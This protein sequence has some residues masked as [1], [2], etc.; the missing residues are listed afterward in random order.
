MSRVTYAVVLVWLLCG[1][2]LAESL[3]DAP[4]PAA[5]SLVR[6]NGSLNFQR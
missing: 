5:I 1:P 3:E 2:A 4:L 6:E